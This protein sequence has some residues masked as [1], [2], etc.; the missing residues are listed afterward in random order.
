MYIST[1]EL[2]KII[3]NF[4]L[5]KGATGDDAVALA[6]IHEQVARETGA[7]IA[8]AVDALDI[9]SVVQAVGIPVFS[10][11]VDPVGF[12][13]SV[14]FVSP[15]AVKKAGG[16]GTLLNHSA[17]QIPYDILRKSIEMAHDAGL[18]VVACADTPEKGKE[19]AAMGPDSVAV[20]PPELI[21]GDVSVS[22][23]KPQVIKDSVELIG[24]GKVV[25][26]AGVK[27]GEDVKIAF[28][29]GASGILVASG[30][31][32]AKDPHA[33]LTDLTMGLK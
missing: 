29:L 22:K 6:K 9:K 7:S 11:H 17:H 23:A 4:K 15:Y 27:T 28:D 31:T 12:G 24:R 2:P 32:K 19:V 3:V 1:M 18:Y 30:V 25:I 13:S 14:G 26:G 10:Q 16:V 33:A 20:E 5:D 21:G 8:V